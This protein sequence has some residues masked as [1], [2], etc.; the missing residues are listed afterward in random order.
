[1]EKQKL[2]RAARLV[3][4]LNTR[5]STLIEQGLLV[6]AESNRRIKAT[7]EVDT[8]EMREKRRKAV[9]KLRTFLD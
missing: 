8:P 3:A 9:A 7:Q 6:P 2:T 1:M 5:R 4:E